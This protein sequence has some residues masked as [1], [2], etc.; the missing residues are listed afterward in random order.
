MRKR[1]VIL[2][3][4]GSIGTSTLDV[5]AALS[6]RFEVVGLAAGS[7]AAM[8]AEQARSCRPVAVA[9]ADDRGLGDL[10]TGLPGGT[11]VYTGPSGIVELVDQTDADF[12]VSA[13]V[14]AAGLAPTLRAVE[15]GRQIG[16]ANKESLVV[17]GDLL[18]PLAEKSGATLLPVD[19]EH[20]AVFQALHA[21]QPHE[22]ERIYLTASGGPFRTWDRA[23][24][25]SATLSDALRHPTWQMGPKISID[26]ASMMNKALEVIEARHLFK[27]DS[28]R[29]EVLVH[30]E[31]IIHSMVEFHDASIIAQLGTPDMRTPIQYALTY[32]E[33]QR[34]VSSRLNW[35]EISQLRFETPDFERFPALRM[36]FESARVGGSTGA[37]LNAANEAAVEL[38]RVGRVTFG[39]I[40]RILERVF[41]GHRP[42]TNPTLEQLLQA[43]AWARDEVL[44][45]S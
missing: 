23:R 18:M 44:A 29:I 40:G 21:G 34:G 25:E 4:T 15:L 1:V 7:N 37:V 20:S 28:E 38:F 32:P 9:L 16:L 14:G 10:R 11:R 24:I 19:S 33:R 31:S 13:L 17:A 35:R 41:T 6:D 2:G 39:G 12:V 26:S 3:S 27:I 36:G 8:L 30:P 22:I 5:C 45:C 43:D 42:I